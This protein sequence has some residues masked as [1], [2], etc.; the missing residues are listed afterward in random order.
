MGEGW[1]ITKRVLENTQALVK[2]YNTDPEFRE[3][4]DRYLPNPKVT[5]KNIPLKVFVRVITLISP[6]YQRYNKEVRQNAE[7]FKEL[8]KIYY[9]DWREYGKFESSIKATLSGQPPPLLT[10]TEQQLFEKIEQTPDVKEKNQLSE[11]LNTQLDQRSVHSTPKESS[12]Q[13][14]PKDVLAPASPTFHLPVSLKETLRRP[15]LNFASFAKVQA[16]RHLPN[17]IGGVI[18][19]VTGLGLTGS[20]LGLF[21]GG[22]GGGILPNILKL[23]GGKALLGKGALAAS[24]IATGGITTAL[25]LAPDIASKAKSVSKNVV[26]IVGSCIGALLLLF[27]PG[28]GF[29]LPGITSLL[30]PPELAESSSFYP[31]GTGGDIASCKFIRGAENPKAASFKSNLLL[32]YFQ[33]ASQVSGVPIVTLAAFARVESPSLVTKTDADLVNFDCATSDTGALGLMQLQPKGTIG[34]DAAAIAQGSSFIGKQYEDLTREDYCDPRKS[35]LMSTGFILKKMSYF[36]YGNGTKWQPEWNNDRKAINTMVSGYYGCPADNLKYGGPDPRKCE[37]PY[38]YGEDVWTSVQSCQLAPPSQAA[39]A[40]CPVPGGKITTPSY[41][42]NP[43][44]GHC[45]GGYKFDCN[46]GTSGRRAKAID[47]ATNGKNVILPTING[48][49]VTWTLTT[50]GYPVNSG[51]GGGVG[52][53]FSAQAG[54]DK[55]YLDMLHL[56]QT[57]LIEGQSYP[58][59][60][61]VGKSAITHVHTTIG[62]NLKERVVPGSSS[63]CDSGWIPSDFMCNN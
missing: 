36:G 21:T 3:R 48:Q 49:S 8:L 58:S 16:I 32:S 23:G 15:L 44:T 38:D 9:Q 46:C 34:H 52:H 45:G 20:P 1:G 57:Q 51:E 56:E 55:W 19:G 18:G 50:K 39:I 12:V 11:K 2:Q 60:T 26:I 61:V 41:N 63:D 30:P 31:G 40:S 25:A 24:G 29:D 37:G 7:K 33:E 5:Y 59:G 54:P 62:K 53:L 27:L 35:V 42:A 43:Q 14:P 10:P 22:L 6:K 13:T 17:L 28:L 4:F 47:I